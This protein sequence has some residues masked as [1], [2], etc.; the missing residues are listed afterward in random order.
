MANKK[1]GGHNVL[2]F[3]SAGKTSVE[4]RKWIRRIYDRVE[5]ILARGA[6][7]LATCLKDHRKVEENKFKEVECVGNIYEME[8]DFD[9][10]FKFN[11]LAVGETFRAYCRLI[12]N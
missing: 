9:D 1:E 8:K 10:S 6:L 3:I 12:L 5:R 4:I 11:F 2:K 7:I